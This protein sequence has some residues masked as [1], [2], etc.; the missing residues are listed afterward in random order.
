M[1]IRGEKDNDYF[2][3]ICDAC[4]TRTENEYKG[5][6]ATGGAAAFRATCK[7]CKTSIT[8]KLWDGLW[9]GLPSEPEI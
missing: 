9:K 6:V 2:V 8:L 1:K 5:R 4:G 3:L 7:Q